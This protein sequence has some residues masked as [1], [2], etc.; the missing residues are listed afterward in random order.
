[1]SGATAI[2]SPIMLATFDKFAD[3]ITYEGVTALKAA[4]RGLG[5]ED[6]WAGAIEGDF[7][8]VINAPA[9]IAAFP[10]RPLPKRL[11]K[12]TMAGRL[13]TVQEWRSAPAAPSTPVFFKCR[14]RGGSQ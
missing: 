7:V 12:V 14:V 2:V 13:Y 10:A 3:P 8:V 9:F 6:N 1:M 4:G 11:D 5:A